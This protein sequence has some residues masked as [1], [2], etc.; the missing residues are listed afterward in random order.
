MEDV[1]RRKVTLRRLQEMKARRERIVALG[2]Y[3]SPMA[4]IAD[5]IGFEMF[6]IGNSGPMSLFGHRD[7]TSVKPDELL[8]MTQGVSRVTRYALIVATMPYASYC[9]S[10]A[11]SVRSAA[12]LVSEGGA[13]AV[14]CHGTRHTAPY[15]GAIT[16]SGIP[17]LGHLGLQSVRKVE[18]SGF[19]VKGRSGAEARSIVDDARALADAGVFAF[20]VERVPSELARYLAES[21]P[22]PVL[23]LG[24]GPLGDGI[25]LVSGD[26]VGYSVFPKPSHAGR[27]VDVRPMI[28]E[29]LRAYLD[30]ARA[31]TYPAEA[32]A[33]HMSPEEHARF[34]AL[35]GGSPAPSAPA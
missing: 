1:K 20:V 31:G 32:E 4:A 27:F 14:Q 3:D 18:Q 2:V 17:V 10:R 21:L 13:E 7:A 22:A 26:A 16:R 33:R 25:Y 9:V 15:I 5:E 34:K 24:S 30:Q 8:F 28:E 19:G 6:V 23:S 12:R 29:G 35:V 11:Q